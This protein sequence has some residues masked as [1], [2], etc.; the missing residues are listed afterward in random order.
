LVFALAFCC[1][2]CSLLCCI[3]TLQ[4]R[5]P[6]RCSQAH[7][8][9]ISFFHRHLPAGNVCASRFFCVQRLRC[10]HVCAA[11]GT[12]RLSGGPPAANPPYLFDDSAFC[13]PAP[14]IEAQLNHR[15]VVLQPCPR[16]Y[17]SSARAFRLANPTHSFVVD[18]F[19]AALPARWWSDSCCCLFVR[20][21][22]TRAARARST[23]FPVAPSALA[24]EQST[25]LSFTIL[26][27]VLHAALLR[28]VTFSPLWASS[29]CLLCSVRIAHPRRSSS[30][31]FAASLAASD[32]RATRKRTALRALRVR[33]F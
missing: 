26:V 6:W 15:A 13:H 1:V 5:A 20:A 28:L 25:R 2:F 18:N 12:V 8:V 29:G 3:A 21:A 10:W 33:A 30:F 16:G 23:R 19:K 9:S 4:T 24:G 14:L 11:A 7:V 27:V 31:A 17:I 22:A 32:R